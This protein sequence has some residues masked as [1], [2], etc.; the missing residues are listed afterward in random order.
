MSSSLSVDAIDMQG[1]LNS[2]SC[3]LT[4]DM[5]PSPSIIPAM[6]DASHFSIKVS[7]FSERNVC[8]YLYF[9]LVN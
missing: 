8:S 7:P 1:R 2:F 6:Y 4:N 3:I 9:I 5:L